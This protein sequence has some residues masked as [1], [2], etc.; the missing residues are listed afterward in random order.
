[1]DLICGLMLV[2]LME[3]RM[4]MNCYCRMLHLSWCIFYTL[5]NSILLVE[6]MYS[7][8]G[9]ALVTFGTGCLLDMKTVIVMNVSFCSMES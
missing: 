1:M 6:V 8:P 3:T 7:I 4:D 2:V 9:S 5:N